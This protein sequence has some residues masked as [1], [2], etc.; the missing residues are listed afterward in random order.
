MLVLISALAFGQDAPPVDAPPPAVEAIPEAAPAPTPAPPPAETAVPAPAPTVA[1]A[2]DAVEADAAT[3]G[4]AQPGGQDIEYRDGQVQGANRLRVGGQVETQW[5]EFDNLDFRALD[6][7][8]DQAILDSDDR[9]S[10]A[11]SG[12]A[13][14]LAYDVDPHTTVAV[15]TSFRGMWGNDQIGQVSAF[16]SWLYFNN[17]Y[18]NAHTTK[19]GPSLTVGRQYYEIGGLAG[20]ADYVLADVVDWVRADIPLAGVGTLILVPVNMVA[21]SADDSGPDFANYIGQSD[22]PVFNLR[23]DRATRRHGAVLQADRLSSTVDLRGYVFYTDVGARGTGADISYDGELGNFADNDWI[24]NAGVRGMAR[25][26]DGKLQPYAHFDFSTGRDRKELVA[27]DVDHYGFAWGGGLAYRGQ[28]VEDDAK[29]NDKRGLDAQLTYF[30][31]LGPAY[32]ENGLQYSHGYTSMK[33]RQVGGLIMN[34]YLGW[35]PTAYLGTDGVADSPNETDRKAG[36]RVLNAGVDVGLPGPVSVGLGWWMAQDTGVTYLSES[37]L[38]TLTPP[39]GY[40]RAEFAAELRHGQTL[41]QEIDATVAG[42]LTSVLDLLAVGGVLLPGAFYQ[43]EIERVAGSALGAT[44]PRMAWG[45]S[46]G[47][48]VRF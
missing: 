18:V 1:Q 28:T 19:G 41:G 43:T 36:T 42:H 35:H 33:A 25:V 2:P 20:T 34:R 29:P 3:G 47:T 26:L 37:A 44:D 24:L 38:A 6:E 22:D 10:L 48:R 4:L 30:D 13:L 27:Q 8:S 16:N 9:G 21:I 17:L 23:G 14:D 39:Y 5:H 7:S 45:V 32:A 40:S 11:F 31:C 15:S 12:A 46:G